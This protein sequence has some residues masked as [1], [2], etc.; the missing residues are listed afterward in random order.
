M[1]TLIVANRSF[2]IPG[3]GRHQDFSRLSE[4]RVTKAVRGKLR[5]HFR[6]IEVSCSAVLVG[7]SWTGDCRI[8]TVRYRY[9]VVRG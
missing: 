9:R 4:K 8:E 3:L 1:P 6:A 5:E 7:A 2:P